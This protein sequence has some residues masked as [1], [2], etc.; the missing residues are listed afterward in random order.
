MQF[1]MYR[2]DLTEKFLEKVLGTL[3]KSS[4]GFEGEARE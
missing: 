2:R 4:R 1:F 3:G